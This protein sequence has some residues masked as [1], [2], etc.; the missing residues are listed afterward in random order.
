MTHPKWLAVLTLLP[1]LGE[2]MMTSAW[3]QG[4]P[5]SAPITPPGSAPAAPPGAPDLGATGWGAAVFVLAILALIVILGAV[6]KYHDMRNRREADALALQS[7]L[8]DMLL[9]DQALHGVA[10]TPTV[11]IPLSGS[12]P[13][14]EVTGDVPSPETRERVLRAV[15]REA[16]SLSAD[17]VEIKDKLLVL[18]PVRTRAA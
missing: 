8:S 15:K 3:A 16:Q 14:V 9:T 17:D 13:I 1:V 11:H 18:P 4:M 2:L 7:R 12:R 10:V 6:A 5:N